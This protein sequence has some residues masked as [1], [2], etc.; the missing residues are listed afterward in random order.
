MRLKKLRKNANLTQK[1]FA[2]AIGA[3]Q[4]TVSQWETGTHGIDND[5]LSRIANFFGVSID[6]LLGNDFSPAEK[7][8]ADPEI[9]EAALDQELI[10]LLCQLDAREALRVQ[11]FVRGLLAAREAP[12]CRQE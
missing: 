11:D 3:A 6:Y 10:Q 7:S 8:P 2:R 9:D 5:T 1:Q 12:A 4:N